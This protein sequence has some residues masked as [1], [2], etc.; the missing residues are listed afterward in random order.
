MHVIP[1]VVIF[2]IRWMPVSGFDVSRPAPPNRYQG[3]RVC[4]NDP[5]EGSN[6][7]RAWSRPHTAIRAAAS[8]PSRHSTL[9]LSRACRSVCCTAAAGVSAGRPPLPVRQAAGAP[10]PALRRRLRA[11]QR[12]LPPVRVE[13]VVG[14]DPPAPR[15]SEQASP[16]HCRA[17]YSR[18][19]DSSSSSVA[20]WLGRGQHRHVC[21]SSCGT[22][23]SLAVAGWLAAAS[24]TCRGCGR[25]A[26]C[27]PCSTASGLP[28][29][30]ASP[31]S[32]SSTR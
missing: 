2:T 29:T 7:W 25:L 16:F 15:L 4:L 30:R 20:A 18:S 27:T 23:G 10:P 19:R 17:A 1:S 5:I 13:A 24:S 11:A 3:A 32:R 26:P 21:H 8:P 12:P 6:K 28:P 14:F 22:V 31:P 9:R